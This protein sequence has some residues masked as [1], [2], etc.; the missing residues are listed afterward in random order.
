MEFVTIR[1]RSYLNQATTTEE[2][3][4]SYILK[5]TEKVSKMTI[6]KLAEATFT[7]P[8]SIVRLC[9]KIDFDGY[10]ELLKAIVHELAIRN[11]YKAKEINDVNKMDQMEAIIYKVTHKNILSLEKTSDIQNKEL[12]ENCLAE[13]LKCD[14]LVFFGI[15]ASLIIAR[16]AH[17]KFTRINKKAYICEDWHTQ[18]LMAKSMTER[19]LAIV[20]SYSGQTKEMITCIKEAKLAG[21]KTISITKYTT[22]PIVELAEYNL[23]TVANKCDFK[24]SGMSSMIAQLNLI[25]ILYTA[26][27]NKQHEHAL[28][29]LKKSN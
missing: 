23:Y 3:I 5:N 22:A 2:T 24:S 19:D 20:I 6:Y 4:V 10:K 12:L 27:I 26:F 7:S 1:L 18:L 14:K 21:A 8:S 17:L 29:I 13:I 15:G 28:K 11:Y 25:E 9:K 16:E